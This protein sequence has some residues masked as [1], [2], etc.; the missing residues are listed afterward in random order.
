M[1]IYIQSQ[2]LSR[3]EETW[4]TTVDPSVALQITAT[5]PGWP[6]AADRVIKSTPKDRL[7]EFKL[8]WRDPQPCW[9]SPGGHVVQLGDAAHTFLPSAGNGAN[10][11]IED[12]ISL[13]ACLQIAGRENIH[14]ATRVHNTLRYSNQSRG[15]RPP[16]HTTNTLANSLKEFRPLVELAYIL[17]FFCLPE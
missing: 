12:A 10:Q 6:D 16:Q 11:A 5:I 7:L 14:W 15:P 4:S 13:A 8:T 9:T 2:N 17:T 1:L 3:A